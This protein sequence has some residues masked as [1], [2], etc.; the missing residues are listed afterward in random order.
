M[1]SFPFPP[2]TL[3]LPP[4][5]LSKGRSSGRED[6]RGHRLHALFKVHPEVSGPISEVGTVLADRRRGRA[7]SWSTHLV[8]MGE[9]GVVQGWPY[10]LLPPA[11]YDYLTDEEERHSA[12][13]STSED[14][15]PEHP[16]LPLV[17]DEDSWYNKWH[18]MEQKFRI[19]YAQKVWEAWLGERELPGVDRPSEQGQGSSW[20]LLRRSPCPAG[21]PGGASATARVTA[22]GPG[23]GE[24]A[25][26]AAAGGSR[27]AE[28]AGEAGA[29][30]RD[31]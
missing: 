28:P 4:Q 14:N 19:V 25:A 30:R 29:G 11:S 1:F 23:G 27:G 22:E 24:S 17:T 18:K 8:G 26:A 7:S 10:P 31:P 9:V 5:L 13:S 2:P 15:S 12:E 20:D 3:A 16:Y 21:L 6:S